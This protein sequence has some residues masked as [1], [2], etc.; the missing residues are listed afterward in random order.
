[1]EMGQ[2]FVGSDKTDR[3]KSLRL[4]EDLRTFSPHGPSR[5][6]GPW[7]SERIVLAV[8]VLD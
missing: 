6:E 1:M 4:G 8:K 5:Y 3:E 7:T 2:D